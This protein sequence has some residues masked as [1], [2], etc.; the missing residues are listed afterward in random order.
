MKFQKTLWPWGLEPR[1]YIWVNS[2]QKMHLAIFLEPYLQFSQTRPHF[3]NNHNMNPIKSLNFEKYLDLGVWDLKTRLGQ[4]RP[5]KRIK[6]NKFGTATPIFTK[7]TSFFEN[8]NMNPVKLW[9]LNEYL[10][11][12]VWSLENIFG[13]LKPKRHIK[14]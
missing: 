13:L 6:H 2:V 5:K 9:N 11:L 3:L 10:D 1:N 4:L 12:W 14:A 8:H 7:N